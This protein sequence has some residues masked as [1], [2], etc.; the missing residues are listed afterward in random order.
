[1]EVIETFGWSLQI[2]LRMPFLLK[3]SAFES[4]LS[5]K[6]FV[7]AESFPFAPMCLA[8]NAV[9]C[10]LQYAAPDKVKSQTA[11]LQKFGKASQWQRAV[12]CLMTLQ[13]QADL[14][15]YSAAITACA[16][17]AAWE[18]A[19]LLVA[20]LHAIRTKLDVITFGAGM[21]ACEKAGVWQQ[22]GFLLQDVLNQEVQ[23]N[24]VVYNAAI[25]AC[26]RGAQWRGAQLLLHEM[27]ER[28][29]QAD[30]IS[31]NSACL[32]GDAADAA[33]VRCE[34]LDLQM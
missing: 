12:E 28:K 1:V 18:Q 2:S 33:D 29:L 4:S 16:K 30:T 14:I 21:S 3:V 17:G 10:R 13:G 8:S 20:N 31:F 26:S 19:L 23:A 15:A 27:C 22:S 32:F 6:Y 11:R 5:L 9:Q 7:A 24:A 34:D 25:S